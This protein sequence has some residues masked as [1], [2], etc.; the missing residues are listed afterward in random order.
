MCHRSTL[1][2]TLNVHVEPDG[3]E[4]LRLGGILVHSAGICVIETEGESP[5][6]LVQDPVPNINISLQADLM[7]LAHLFLLMGVG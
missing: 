1:Q 6:L 2:L 4:D 3:D 7:R 5:H